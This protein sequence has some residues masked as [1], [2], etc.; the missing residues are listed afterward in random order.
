MVYNLDKRFM[1]VVAG[2]DNCSGRGG[3]KSL[4]VELVG[5]M[6][7]GHWIKMENW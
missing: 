2:N 7:S 4:P 6:L 3:A 5:K 1:H